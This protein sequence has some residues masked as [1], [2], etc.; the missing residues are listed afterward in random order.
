[1]EVIAMPVLES[2]AAGGRAKPGGSKVMRTTTA[3]DAVGVEEL[4]VVD[5]RGRGAAPV[6]ACRVAAGTGSAGRQGGNVDTT[7]APAGGD[8]TVE[9]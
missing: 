9:G 7:A 8:E 4:Q 2:A 5:M 6:M 3:R 1:M